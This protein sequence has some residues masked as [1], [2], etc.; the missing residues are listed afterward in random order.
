MNESSLEIQHLVPEIFL[1][2]C[3]SLSPKPRQI[4]GDWMDVKTS[5]TGDFRHA[6]K[7]SSE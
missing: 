3:E 7:W 4:T 1:A 5:L 2:C 6:I